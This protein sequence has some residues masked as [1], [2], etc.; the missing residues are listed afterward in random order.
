MS[1]PSNTAS[2]FS[3]TERLRQH[4]PAALY[5]TALVAFL[6]IWHWK[7]TSHLSVSAVATFATFSSMALIFGDFFL[8]LSP[9]SPRLAGAITVQFLFGFFLLNTCLFVLS[10]ATELGITNCFLILAA[11]ALTIHFVRA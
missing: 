7:T 8:R 9:L 5:V 1:A 6:C 4:I 11:V 2:V 10:L 3:V